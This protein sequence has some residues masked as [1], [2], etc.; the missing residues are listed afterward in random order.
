MADSLV[1]LQSRVSSTPEHMHSRLNQRGDFSDPMEDE[2]DTYEVGA[3]YRHVSQQKSVWSDISMCNREERWPSLL[4]A[5][6]TLRLS[7]VESPE[8]EAEGLP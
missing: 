6:R 5:T 8:A 7:V 2:R 1:L 3:V 4:I